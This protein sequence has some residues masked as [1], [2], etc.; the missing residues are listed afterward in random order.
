[1]LVVVINQDG[2]LDREPHG[3]LL[4]SAH[5]LDPEVLV[6]L[7]EVL[8]ALKVQVIKLASLGILGINIP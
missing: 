1:M 5:H 3:T 6:V 2:G 7:V 4:H 8:K